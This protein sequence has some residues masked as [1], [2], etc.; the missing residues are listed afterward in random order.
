MNIM[1]ETNTPQTTIENEQKQNAPSDARIILGPLVKYALMGLV[2]VS[3]IIT[4]AVM[5]DRQF[6]DIDR[7]VAALEA[8]LAE[9]NQ[10][11]DSDTTFASQSDATHAPVANPVQQTMTDVNEGAVADKFTDTETQMPAAGT[12]EDKVEA[13]T[14]VQSAAEMPLIVQADTD[15]KKTLTEAVVVEEAEAVTTNENI[16]PFD[17]SI[18]AL[19]DERNAYLRQMDHI[20]LDELKA[21]QEKQLQLMRERLARQEQRIKEMEARFQERYEVRAGNVKEMQEQRESFLTDRI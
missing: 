2:L 13:V 8:E 20:Y 14:D 5:L 1:S 21:S 3:A 4:T 16:D 10:A 6:N 17:Q 7:E 19:I 11:Y 18:E 9:A 12:P 15:E